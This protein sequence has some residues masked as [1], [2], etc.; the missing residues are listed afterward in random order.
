MEYGEYLTMLKNEDDISNLL[1]NSIWHFSGNDRV[2]SIAL[3][4]HPDGRLFGYSHRNE[5]R[6]TIL[7]G[8]LC[9]MTEQGRL[10]G[11]LSPVVGDTEDITFCGNSL[12][13]PKVTFI[14]SPVTWEARGRME[15]MTRA[16]FA[17]ES[18]LYG[19]EI[20]DHTYGKPIVFEKTSKLKIGKFVSIA[21][22]VG[23]ALGDH[24]IDSV[25]S[26]P[27]PTLRRWWPSAGSPVDHV[28]KGDVVIGNDVWIGAGSF[29]TSGVTVGD[30]AVIA[31]HAV[32]T[33]NVP[34]YAIVGG[35]PARVLRYRFPETTID[36]LLRIAWWNWSDEKIDRFLPLMFND[37]LKEFLAQAEREV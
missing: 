37:E 12:V 31:G 28:S 2:L 14:L 5:R 30:G 9:F 34:P 36:R 25:S 3:R 1:T 24:R 16:A 21:G 32:V 27:F 23:I 33:K 18:A 11:R 10:T 26:Y 13:D 7:D 15:T 22:G 20:G 4:F 8:Q 17:G 35:N 6:W 29:I 19:W